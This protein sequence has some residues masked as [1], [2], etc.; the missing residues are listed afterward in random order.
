MIYR[1]ILSRRAVNDLDE[2]YLW[3]V[4]H[5]PFTAAAWRARFYDKLQTLTKNP[6]RCG[7]AR[8]N[9][10]VPIEIRQLLFGKR[11]N[12]YRVLFTLDGGVVRILRI[13]RAQQRFLSRR[14]LD[15]ASGPELPE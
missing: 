12:I 7:F 10:K 3:A 9:R 2:S 1:V 14:E 4:R 11:P 13:R 5:A 6:Q 15:E 8:E